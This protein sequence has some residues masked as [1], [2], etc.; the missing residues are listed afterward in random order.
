MALKSLRQLPLCSTDG[1]KEKVNIQKNEKEIKIKGQG[2][3]GETNA[4]SLNTSISQLRSS[5]MDFSLQADWQT[6]D[7]HGTE[8]VEKYL[9]YAKDIASL[10]EVLQARLV[11]MEHLRKS[12]SRIVQ[13]EIEAQ[14]FENEA[15]DKNRLKAGGSR[16]LEEAVSQALC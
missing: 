12:V 14:S 13:M 10:K 6:G 5:I 3:S 11:S 4:V 7:V 8:L 16:L 15:S 1:N 9:T 2:D